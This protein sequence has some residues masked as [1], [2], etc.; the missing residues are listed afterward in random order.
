MET[1]AGFELSPQQKR[2]WQLQ[3]ADTNCP[4]RAQCTVEIKGE[5]EANLLQDA[6]AKVISNHEILR[7]T[8]NK[9]SGMTFPLQVISPQ[10][11]FNFTQYD[12]RGIELTEQLNKIDYLWQQYNQFSFDFSRNSLFNS[13][14][15]SLTDAESLLLLDLPALYIDHQGLDNLVKAISQFYLA[16]TKG[17]EIDE[18]ILQYAD[19]SEWQNQLLNDEEQ[20]LVLAKGYWREH[21][22]SNQLNIKLPLEKK[23][24]R[25]IGFKP[26]SLNFTFSSSQFEQIAKFC[27]EERVNIDLFFLT[28]WKILLW[29]IIQ[30]TEMVIGVS[31]DGRKHEE[32]K[33]S[34]GLLARYLPLKYNFQKSLFFRDILQQIQQELN[35]IYSWQYQF[36]WELIHEKKIGNTN[37][38]SIPF[39][40]NFEK[41]KSYIVDN[42]S[43]N[44]LKQ[45]SYFDRFKLKLNIIQS[46][47]NIIAKLEYDEE[48]FDR[49]YIQSLAEQFQTLVASVLA[50]PKTTIDRLTILSDSERKKILVDFNDTSCDYPQDKCLHQLFEER[51]EKNPDAVAVVFEEQQLTYQQLNQQANQLA[52][53]LQSLGV[54]PE[55]LVAICVERSLEM[56]IGLLAILKAG[57]AYIPLDPNYP[58]DR[59]NYMLQD[60]GVEILLTQQ[61]LL[62]TLPQHNAKII[63]LNTDWETVSQ[64]STE[65][66]DIAITADNLAYG[67]YTSGSTGKPKGV[68]IAHRAI[69][70]HVSWVV[71]TLSLTSS[72]KV[73]QKTPFSF[74]PSN[75]EFYAPLLAGGQLILAQPGGHRDRDYLIRL[76]NQQQITMFQLVPSLLKVF[77]ETEDLRHCPSLKHIVCGGEA[78][79]AELCQRFREQSQA[80]LHNHYGPTEACITSTSYICNEDIQRAIAPIGRAIANAQVYILDRQLQPVPIGIPGEL[81]IGGDGLA[82]GYFNL[83]EVTKERFISI[84]PAPLTKGSAASHKGGGIEDRLYKTGDLACYLPDG[85]IEFLGRIDYQ[86]KVRGFRIELGEVETVL[87]SHP[88]IQQAVVIVTEDIPEDRRLV[89]Y[90]VT[91][92]K[93]LSI[94]QLREF[95]QQTLPEYSIPNAFVVLD[96]LPLTPSGKIDRLA[97]PAPDKEITR[98][99]EYV[100]PRTPSEEILTDIFAS[101]LGVEKVGIEDSFF[102]MGGHS[103]LAIQAVSRINQEFSIELTLP[104]MFETPTIAR[105]A[106][107]VIGLQLQN[108]E[109]GDINDLLEESAELLQ[110]EVK[111]PLTSEPEAF[112]N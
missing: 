45:E 51:V 76:I 106:E 5:I 107:T 91:S 66:L 17:E 56:I 33:D 29:R 52:H 57:G 43:F 108:L 79:S 47:Q 77:L 31:C 10:V 59:L 88:Q 61:K 23:L 105:L 70:N 89:A 21:N 75:S 69:V 12:Y 28:C 6:I 81:Y 102:E 26:H 41:N 18:E 46:Q 44:I 85:N 64:Q 110:D 27:E 25:K 4:Y 73:L 15:V 98:E 36:G 65:N 42:I 54:K 83:P 84:P 72:D 38:Y 7:T 111:Q 80:T 14:L 3:E 78:L 74:D 112:N 96:Q 100:A 40:F 71:Q 30:E 9:V 2:L 99:T 94:S 24:A 34:V 60:S 97:L 8:F 1:I 49:N 39:C 22:I 53:Y 32:L 93:S 35:S 67:I 58:E 20:E 55:V 13:A 68:A 86:V 109:E 90:L 101:L 16:C 37:N 48:L 95:L 103:L 104:Q 87:N 19:I 63:C 50:S 82:R 11:N 62:S 92:D